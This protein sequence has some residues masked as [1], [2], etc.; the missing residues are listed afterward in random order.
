MTELSFEGFQEKWNAEE[1]NAAVQALVQQLEDRQTTS[2]VGQAA[3]ATGLPSWDNVRRLT[4]NYR[5]LGTMGDTPDPRA[6]SVAAYDGS[7]LSG[8][9]QRFR[10]DVGT[11]LPPMMWLPT[12]TQGWLRIQAMAGN[13]FALFGAGAEKATVF[14]LIVTGIPHDLGRMPE[15]CVARSSSG[16]N[17]PTGQRCAINGGTHTAP[18]A[19]GTNVALDMDFIPLLGQSP[20]DIERQLKFLFSFGDGSSTT[21]EHGFGDVPGLAIPPA[22]NRFDSAEF[23]AEVLS[24]LVTTEETFGGILLTTMWG[25]QTLSSIPTGLNSTGGE[26]INPPSGT[27]I[28]DGN[29]WAVFPMEDDVTSQRIPQMSSTLPGLGKSLGVLMMDLGN[30]YATPQAMLSN[31][32]TVALENGSVDFIMR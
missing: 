10:F 11:R 6:A 29:S 17:G 4:L 12:S 16:P 21:S 19:S 31:G 1:A 28:W 9:Y 15:F 8:S 20:L 32:L 5:A 26:I 23:L 25:Q 18:F 24:D 27:D 7:G 3:D 30:S 2:P 13:L 14:G 22:F